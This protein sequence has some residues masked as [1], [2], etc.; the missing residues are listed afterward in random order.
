MTVDVYKPYSNGGSG[1]QGYSGG[2]RG[3]SSYGG[4]KSYGGNS[5]YGGGNSSYGGGS[6]F[7]GGGYGG[8][9][10]GGSGFGGG[11][12]GVGAGAGLRTPKWDASNMKPFLKNFYQPCPSAAA[13]SPIEVKAFRDKH[14]IAVIGDAPGPILQ[15]REAN[16]PN[17]IL[18]QLQ[19]N[20][21][22]A[23]TPIQAQGWPIA[24]TGKNL[25]GIAQTGSG[26]TLAYLLPAAIHIAN[27]EPLNRGEGPIV[28]VMAPTR[29]LAQQIQTIAREYDQV[30]MRSTCVY[31]GASKGPQISALQSGVE[32]V[33]ATPGRL[34]DLLKLGKTN[35]LRTTFVVLDEADRMLDMGFEPQI[36]KVM[37]QIRPDRQVL[38]WSATWPKEVQ[39]LAK[40]FLKEYVQINIGSTDLSANHN[41]KQVVEVCEDS[42]K[43]HRLMELL[44]EIA[45]ERESKTIVFAETKRKVDEIARQI[46][47]SGIR[48]SGIHGD[49]NQ[50]DRDIALRDF[51]TGRID[52]LVATD[53]AARGLDVDDVKFVINYDFP[54]V[55]EDYIHRIGRTGRSNQTG[56][57]YTF[58]TRKNSK[59][60][61]ELISVLREAN[62]EVDPKLQGLARSGGFGG[63]SNRRWGGPPSRGGSGGGYRGN[64]SGGYQGNRGGSGGDWRSNN[65]NS[66]WNS[67][68]NTQGQGYY[69]NSGNSGSWSNGGSNNAGQWG[70][71]Q[72]Y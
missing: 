49:K 14:E 63:S 59:Q 1:Y 55:S 45:Q 56:T 37:E 67:S 7:G 22:E 40:D 35:L 68:N 65:S 69:N 19:R 64:S 51:R 18:Q 25:V 34:L 13:R 2:S 15:F 26:K 29:E 44:R 10:F 24:M 42:H 31:G 12:F 36:R 6:K 54:H 60:A 16:F 48:V 20:G 4:N 17:F 21:F 28:L 47:Y 52:V 5:S 46:R 62:Q 43:Q 23:P 66:S 50:Q 3:G 11:K 8:G 38:M 30:R 33:I 57:A 27:Q 9:K 39:R 32:I 58:F 71:A 53:V 61:N 70:A 41:I 72:Q